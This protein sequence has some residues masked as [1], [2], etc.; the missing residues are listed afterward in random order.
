MHILIDP[1]FH[2]WFS[3]AMTVCA[4]YFFANEKMPLELSSALILAILLLFGQIF[5]LFDDAGKNMLGAEKL[6]LGFA[7]PS[8]IAVLSLLVIGQA[9]VQTAALTPITRVFTGMKEKYAF[10]GL[11]SIFLIVMIVSAFLN[12]TPLVIIAI[13]VLQALGARMGISDSKIMIPLSF[14]AILGGMMT[15]VGSSTNMLVSTAMVDLGYEGFEFFDFTVPGAFLA[16]VGAVYVFLVVPRLLPNR[17]TM[18][19]G[20][21]DKDKH[22]I[23]EIVIQP[24]S[25]LVGQ[26]YDEETERF[27]GLPEDIIIRMIQRQGALITED[28]HE[29]TLEEHDVII[30]AATRMTLMEVLETNPGYLL[31]DDTKPE[32]KVIAQTEGEEGEEEQGA[33][34]HSLVEV[35]ITPTSHMVDMSIAQIEFEKHFGC[36]VLGIQRRANIVRRRLHQMRLESGDV[37]LVAGDQDA[38]YALRDQKDLIVM[39]GTRRDIPVTKKAPHAAI[40]FAATIGLAATSVLPIPVAAVAGAVA[41]VVFGCLNMRQVMRAFDRKI[42]FL[43]GSALALGTCLQVTEGATY[44]AGLLL[45]LPAL[46]DPF[47]AAMTLFIIVAICTNLLTNNACAILFTPI[48]M[49]LAESIGADPIVFA[50]TVVFAANCSFAS[51]IGYQTNLL[52]MGPGHY[53]F[54]DFMKTGIPLVLI[55]WLAYALLAKYYFNL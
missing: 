33:E 11:I 54:K 21:A 52:V 20:L 30:A 32:E 31:D 38:I 18:A 25:K 51:P 39:A 13:P 10:I 50:M 15:L 40:V 23:A 12:N 28:F 45:D 36:M 26:S 1:T 44:I 7:N 53:Q 48:A 35:M 16:A 4:F 2:M 49:N 19:G 29:I 8:L 47:F 24:E 17:T 43:V 42:Y 6:L 37:L 3:I 5:P 34:S 14:I 46:Q 22:F 27:P 55:I 41:M 9:M